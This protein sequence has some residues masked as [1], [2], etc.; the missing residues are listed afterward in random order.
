[1]LDQMMEQQVE[2]M[3]K[4]IAD[5]QAKRTAKP[6]VKYQYDS[7]LDPFVILGIKRDCTETEFKAAYKKKAQELHPD[8]GGD[9]EKF[10]LVQAAYEAV[11]QFRGWK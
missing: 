6:G 9:P 4:I 10:K 7:S 3:K 1:M 11:K 5:R 2:K 8:H